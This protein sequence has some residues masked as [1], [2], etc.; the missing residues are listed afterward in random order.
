MMFTLLNEYL[1][2]IELGEPQQSKNLVVVP[3]LHH[4]ERVQR[5]KHVLGHAGCNQPKAFVWL[6]LGRLFPA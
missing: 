2:G 1:S 6:A 4:G 3:P 5:A